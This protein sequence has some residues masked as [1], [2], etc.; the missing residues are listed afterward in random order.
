MNY[1]LYVFKY[2]YSYFKC[3]NF[4]FGYWHIVKKIFK[5]VSYILLYVYIILTKH[6]LLIFI[7]MWTVIIS[8]VM[9]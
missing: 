8:I 6:V 7:K 2:K 1:F 5:I 4:Y 3:Y 9:A